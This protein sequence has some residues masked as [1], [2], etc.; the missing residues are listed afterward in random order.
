MRRIKNSIVL[1]AFL[2]G[3]LFPQSGD[4][5]PHMM[6]AGKPAKAKGEAASRLASAQAPSAPGRSSASNHATGPARLF[7]EM[8][9]GSSSP[10]DVINPAS[11]A[12]ST[13]PAATIGLEPQNIVTPHGGGSI[14]SVQVKSLRL[15]AGTA[16]R[17]EWQDATRDN[18]T[19]HQVRFRDA[20]AIQFPVGAARDTVLSMGCPK[21]PV[22]IWQWKADWE[23]E[24]PRMNDA[25]YTGNPY[26]PPGKGQNLVYKRLHVDS[27]LEPNAAQGAGGPASGVYNLFP[28]GAHKS[29]VENIVAVGISTVTTKPEMYQNLRG[30]GVWQNG[31]WTVVMFQPAA[32]DKNQDQSSPLFMP[33]DT[34]NVAIAVW[35]G[36]QQDRNGMKS[37]SNWTQ[38]KI[39]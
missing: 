22:N 6:A 32:K 29:S 19:V 17:F 31:K 9:A 38:L 13:A 2:V 8:V 21:G 5:K 34:M 23:P 14:K 37:I 30:K 1:S 12:W 16:F 18:D 24:A 15:P 25:P 20:V 35:N 7:I 28:Q 33:G 4:C 27:C 39:K 3:S 26:S 10:D 36:S 11:K